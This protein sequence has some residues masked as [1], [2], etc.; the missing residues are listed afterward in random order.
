MQGFVLSQL[1]WPAECSEQ[2]LTAPLCSKADE[3]RIQSLPQ[4]HE[5][6]GFASSCLC[7]HVAWVCGVLSP[8]ASFPT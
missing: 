1:C 2:D 6:K 7:L 8:R 3:L 4:H 5:G